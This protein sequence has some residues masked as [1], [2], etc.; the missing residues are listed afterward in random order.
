MSKRCNAHMRNINRFTRTLF[1]AVCLLLCI[2]MLGCRASA[3]PEATATPIAIP[4]ATPEPQPVAG[5]ELYIPI[6]RNPFK[7]RR[8]NQ[9]KPIDSEYGR[10]AQYVFAGIR[11]TAS[12]R[13][14]Q[15]N[16]PQLS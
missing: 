2:G 16:Y 15:S 12:L 3:K 13:R 8:R 14:E 9:R 6:P 4:T 11:T 7:S 10:N 1:S 5:G